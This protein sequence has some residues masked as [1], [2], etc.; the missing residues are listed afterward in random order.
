[1][2][3]TRRVAFALLL[4]L[5]GCADT[6]SRQH[7]QTSIQAD[8]IED[9]LPQITMLKATGLYLTDNPISA[10][11]GSLSV[12]DDAV[13]RR[14]G[15]MEPRRGN[16]SDLTTSSPVRALT[17]YRGAIIG[18]TVAGTLVRRESA[19]S[20]LVYSGDYTPPAGTFRTRFAQAKSNLYLTSAAGVYRLDALDGT[21]T[22]S[23]A[24]VAL[25]GTGATS[26]TSGFLPSA[27]AVA[28]RFVWGRRDANGNLLLGAPSGRLVVPFNSYAAGTVTLGGE[29][30]D[31][32]VTINGTAVGPVTFNTSDAQ[33]ALDT[34]TAINANATTSALVTATSGGSGVITITADAAGSSGDAITLTASRTAG[35]AT[36]SGATL[37]GGNASR[38]VVVTAPIPSGVTAGVDFLQIYRTETREAVDGDPGEEMALVAEEFPTEADVTAGSFSY[39]DVTTSP[40]GPTG[41]FTP[42]QGG[43]VGSK[44]RPPVAR[45]VAFYKGHAF[46]AVESARQ[47]VQMTLLAVGG[48]NGLDVG[49]AVRFIGEEEAWTEDYLA[50]AGDGES[51]SGDFTVTTSGT[52]AQNIEA[53][54]RS[55][56]RAIN[57][58]SGGRLYA[59]YA[60]TANDFP[61][62]IIVQA[63]SLS[64][65]PFGIVGLGAT[66][67]WSP[68]LS[69]SVYVQGASRTS[70]VV[71]LITTTDHNFSVGQVVNVRV[72]TSLGAIFSTGLKTITEVPS[73]GMFKYAETGDNSGVIVTQGTAS[74]QNATLFSDDGVMSSTWAMSTF[75]EPESVPPGNY[76]TVGG[77]TS[78]LYRI[79]AQ[80]DGLWFFTSEGLYRLSGDTEANFTLRPF[81]LTVKLVAPDTV[82]ALENRVWAL[83]DQGVVAIS[84]VGVETM[85]HIPGRTSIQQ[86]LQELFA[87]FR[88]ASASAS[89]ASY[90]FAMAYET[91]HEYRLWLPATTDDTSAT[92]AYVFNTQHGAWTKHNVPA[93]HAIVL[94]EEDRQYLAKPTAALA[95]ER[96][97][98][99]ASDLQDATGVGVPFEVAYTVL[100][101]DNP[102]TL[103]QWREVVVHLETPVPATVGVCLST[104]V[105]PAEECGTLPTNGLTTVR[106]YVPTEKSYSTTL[107]VGVNHATS[108][109]RASVLGISVLYTE[110]S[111]AVR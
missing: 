60:S 109:E 51:D 75:E 45:D 53:T 9:P 111:N 18:E 85:S 96:K 86:P 43:I 33:T 1:M 76:F 89:L 16:A 35:T 99:T 30:G 82:V 58:R 67:V 54:T 83:T 40:N 95:R 70:N 64:E 24:P 56:V 91:E 8:P 101:A 59:T 107:T 42:S 94:P 47:R 88:E 65:G 5:A 11:A 32:T 108:A 79:I 68:A 49:Y 73:S 12:A 39:T 81:D 63:R 80:G 62:I 46:Y 84:D 90:A 23:G 37:T 97:A 31:V 106:T 57:L 3:K 10:P 52:A 26:G 21:P 36:A 104:E 44:D 20:E 100:T 77:E 48:S 69:R 29:A 102:G 27:S 14:G 66:D 25:E 105:S 2:T 19:S 4:A 74:T 55:L 34:I 110:V 28:Y 71:T 87:A 103:K 72:V 93:L 13:I 15:V 38:D 41:Y 17:S 78:T 92:F 7:F 50:T 22:L 6:D 61:G 98:L